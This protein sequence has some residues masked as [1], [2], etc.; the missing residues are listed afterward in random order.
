MACTHNV[1]IAWLYAAYPMHAYYCARDHNAWKATVL[2]LTL[3]IPE[4]PGAVMKARPQPYPDT[5]ESNLINA[6]P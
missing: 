1:H 2:P 3:D 6:S 4:K 5:A